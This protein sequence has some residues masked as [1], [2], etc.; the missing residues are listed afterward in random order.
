MNKLISNNQNRDII[1]YKIELCRYF[2]KNSLF[3]VFDDIVY[4]IYQVPY[5]FEIKNLVIFK[6]KNISSI[7]STNIITQL[8]IFFVVTIDKIDAI[9]YLYISR[10][11][12]YS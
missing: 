5:C 3:L 9:V 2:Q 8:V 7:I 6:R 11:V 4:Q 1:C 10:R 12:L